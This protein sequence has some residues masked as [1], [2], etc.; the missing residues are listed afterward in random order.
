MNLI[1]DLLQA[2]IITTDDALLLTKKLSASQ[3]HIDILNVLRSFLLKKIVPDFKDGG[4]HVTLYN[5]DET[6]ALLGTDNMEHNK[7]LNVLISKKLVGDAVFQKLKTRNIP[8]TIGGYI[9]LLH[10]AAELE[11]Y[12]INFA[13]EQQLAFA[14]TLLGERK[15]FLYNGILNDEQFDQLNADIKSEKL[16]TYLDF[17]NYSYCCKAVNIEESAAEHLVIDILIPAL[18]KLIYDGFKIQSIGIE[19]SLNTGHPA[20]NSEMVVLT[21]YTGARKYKHSYTCMVNAR[22]KKISNWQLIENILILINDIL[23]DFAAPYRF[24]AITNEHHPLLFPARDDRYMICRLDRE[25]QHVLEFYNMQRLSLFNQPQLNFQKVLSY[26][27]IE[28]L[29]YHFKACGLLNHLSNHVIEKTTASLHEKT[30]QNADQLLAAFPGTAATATRYQIPNHLPYLQI[31]EAFNNMA[32]GV[33]TFTD[34][35]DN[36]PTIASIGDE[37]GYEVNFYCNGVRHSVTCQYHYGEFD[38]RVLYYISSEILNANFQNLILINLVLKG[39]DHHAYRL[40]TCTQQEYLEQANIQLGW[41][42]F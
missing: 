28:Y 19:Q 12:D 18:N 14:K 31:L 42:R 6:E 16:D 5:P 33:L 8:N 40:I 25:Q 2:G 3:N 39:I 15:P 11:A 36:T 4:F 20:Y 23:A 22:V 24:T 32:G 29:I 26:K 7:L 21:L 35:E 13:L 34:I 10:T 9:A 37:I 38:E 30:Y 1:N 41:R 27:H 17:F